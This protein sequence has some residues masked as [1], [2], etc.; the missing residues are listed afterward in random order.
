MEFL[1]LELIAT[2][3]LFLGHFTIVVRNRVVGSAV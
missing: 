3:A 2:A 1:A